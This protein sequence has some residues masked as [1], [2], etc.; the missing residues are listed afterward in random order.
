MDTHQPTRSERLARQARNLLLAGIVAVLGLILLNARESGH[1]LRVGS[2]Q[3]ESIAAAPNFLA[4][5]TATG[6]N[7][8]YIIDTAEQVIC[9]YQM[10]GDTP[11]LVSVR[12]FSV[13]TDIADSSIE[14]I[15]GPDGKPIKIEGGSG[16]NTADAKAYAEGFAKLLEEAEKKKR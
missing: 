5:S 7:S 4:L 12:N 13:D 16:V 11:R 14:T 9:V 15:R 6:A 2:A 1:P 10:R 8:F 3:A